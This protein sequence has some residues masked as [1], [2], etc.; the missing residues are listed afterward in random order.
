L[1][2]NESL[3]VLE[4]IKAMLDSGICMNTAP[5]S[6]EDIA[7]FK[8]DAVATYPMAVWFGGSLKDYAPATSGEWGVFRLPAFE[9]GGLRVSNLGGSVLVIPEETADKEGAWAFVEFCLCNPKTQ[10]F[11]YE[12]FD[13]FPCLTT[14]FDDPF[15]DEPD[16][17]YAGQQVR[18]L[19]ATE[20]DQ[21]PTLNRTKDWKE[22]MRYLNQDLVRWVSG[23]LDA[24]E[25]LAALELKLS[26]RLNREIAPGSL[27]RAEVQ[28]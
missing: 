9:P 3:R 24:R 12:Q 25:V 19:F 16:P 11:Q 21:I 20:I 15:F 26:R 27:S 22:A 7:G 8:T 5:F 23:G 28:P 10:L 2:S 17:F 13:L 1:Y 6:H 14:T 4:L 18:R